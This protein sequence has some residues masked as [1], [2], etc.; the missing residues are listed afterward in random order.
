VGA[1]FFLKQARRW[2]R[3]FAVSM[4]GG[5]QGVEPKDFVKLSLQV[6]TTRDEVLIQ[7]EGVTVAKVT[8]VITRSTIPT[9]V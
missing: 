5:S 4:P 3:N 2:Q 8:V 7:I 1:D 6:N 9:S